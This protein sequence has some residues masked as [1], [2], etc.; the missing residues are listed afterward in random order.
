MKESV[1]LATADEGACAGYV[2][3]ARTFVAARAGP[4]PFR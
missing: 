1:R 3:E 2:L 4:K